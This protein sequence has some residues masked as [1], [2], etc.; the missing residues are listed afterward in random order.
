MRRPE[1]RSNR[2]CHH[3]PISEVSWCV[4]M[5]FGGLHA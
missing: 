4:L 1:L 5:V 3:G 2:Y